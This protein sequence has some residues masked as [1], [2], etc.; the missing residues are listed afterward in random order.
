[1]FCNGIVVDHLKGDHVV[2]PI[3]LSQATLMDHICLFAA[4]DCRSTVPFGFEEAA[5]LESFN[6]TT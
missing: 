3:Q 4:F 1:M 6:A 2:S 5:W